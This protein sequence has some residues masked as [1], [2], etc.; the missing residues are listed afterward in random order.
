M[1]KTYL[2]FF[3]LMISL[4]ACT[5]SEM[6]PDQTMSF[7][8]NPSVRKGHLISFQEKPGWFVPNGIANID[9]TVLYNDQ[10]SLRL[11]NTPQD[12]TKINQIY[13]WFNTEM[14]EGDSIIFS[15]KFRYKKADSTT[16]YFGIQQLK[17]DSEPEN[18]GTDLEKRSGD[19]EWEDFTVKAAMSSTT[20]G[21]CFFGFT[22]G[23]I[24]LWISGWQAEIDKK[25]IGSQIGLVPKADSD[26]GFYIGS[27]I[28]LP[29]PSAQMLD[30]LEVLCKVWGFLKYYHPEVCRGNYN[31]DYELFRVLPQIAN[32]S[33]KIQ[34]SR[35]LS[36]WIDRYGKITEV[37]PYT[38]DDPGLYS[39]I[40]DLSWINDRE[41]FDDKL[42]SKLN[43]IRDAKRSKKFNYYIIPYQLY[44][45]GSFDREKGYPN[46]TWQDQGFRILTLFRLWNAMEYCFPYVDMTDKP[47]HSLIK[48]FLP[49]FVTPGS[50]ADYELAVNKLAACIDDSHGFVNIPY[51][52]LD[53]TILKRKNDSYHIPVTLMESKSGDIVVR[54]TRTYEM[55]RGDIICSVN[56]E[57][58]EEFI[59]RFKPYIPASNHSGLVRNVIPWL[60]RTDTNIMN[61]TCIR[62]GKEVQLELKNFGLNKRHKPH[63]L[64]EMKY[65]EDYNPEAKGI[66]Y[67]NVT[68]MDAPLITEIIQKNK[69]AKGIILDMRKYPGMSAFGTLSPLLYPTPQ[70]FMWFSY[71][72]KAAPGN[73]K[74]TFKSKVGTDNPDYFKGK[75]A[76]LV[77]EGTQSH[78]E[79]SAMAYRKAPQSAIIGSIT[80][81]ADGNVGHFYLS[82]NTRFNYTALGAYYP[83]WGIC[84]RKGIHIDIEARPT[85]EEIRNGQDV[86]M[87]KA[88]EYI[89]K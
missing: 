46:I 71:N 39:R 44:S 59:E 73:Y 86:W 48:E 22:T 26:N 38:I 80:A 8:N 16:I 58:V 31:W 50:K 24:E 40:I 42:I 88:I 34:R 57:T 4:F 72:E 5:H 60:L 6:S 51:S 1:N 70:E 14:I 13:Y 61:V 62:N 64:S 23:D 55:E 56:G 33:D 29:K 37:Q 69:K 3:F 28:V 54:D 18:T 35:L 85:N 12:T 87:E 66:A 30:N 53:K 25:P 81:G 77:N 11:V 76:I 17:I 89:L 52:D 36:E 78:G 65:P 67:I 74:L 47:W 41:M 32:A 27:T 82:G 9:S 84:Q 43:T 19:S 45:Q 15:G 49:K 79:F 63:E 10:K 2:P 68:S 20:T 75:V 83:N 21:I 7:N